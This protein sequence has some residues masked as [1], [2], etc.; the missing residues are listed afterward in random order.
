MSETMLQFAKYKADL[1]YKKIVK[2][3]LF[4]IKYLSNNVCI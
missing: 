4:T 3:E 2:I 1:Q